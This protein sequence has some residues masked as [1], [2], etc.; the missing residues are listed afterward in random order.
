MC[1]AVPG[2]VTN[3]D[4]NYATVDFGGARRRV[5][6]T[7]LEDIKVGE[8]VLVH[9]GYAIQKVSP[10]DAQETWKLWSEILGEEADYRF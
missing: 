6:V 10:R 3:V 2:R 1:F 5:N 9:V 8:Y 4:G 7:L